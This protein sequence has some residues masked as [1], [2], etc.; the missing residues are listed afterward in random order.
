VVERHQKRL[1]DAA[2]GA[3]D[4]MGLIVEAVSAGLTVGEICGAL[5][6]VFGRY[7]EPIFL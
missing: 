4:L 7:Q 3:D 2:R 1:V 5:G 6:T